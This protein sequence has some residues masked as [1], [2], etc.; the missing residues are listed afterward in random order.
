MYPLPVS[1]HTPND[2]FALSSKT[3][4][5]CSTECQNLPERFPL[6]IFGLIL[7]Q[8]SD[9]QVSLATC[10][11]ISSPWLQLSRSHLYGKVELSINNYGKF[12]ELLRSDYCSISLAV[13]HLSLVES[14]FALDKWIDRAVHELEKRLPNV[15]RLRIYG[16]TWNN[17][18]YSSERALLNGFKNVIR[19]HLEYLYS[20]DVTSLLAF[21]CSFPALESLRCTYVMLNDGGDD[22][23]YS[24]LSNFQLPSQVCSIHV[25]HPEDSV[26][27]WL[28]VQTCLKNVRSLELSIS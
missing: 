8:L 6:E 4:I 7:E 15:I 5:R 11:L 3:D 19:L 18:C 9:C 28:V 25:E 26:L 12:M 2:A 27:D 24:D 21:L 20:D 10:A 17:L 22:Q 23:S 14:D 13:R 1:C 16:L